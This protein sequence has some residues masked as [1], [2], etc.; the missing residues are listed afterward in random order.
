MDTQ[1]R[2]GMMDALRKGGW[3]DALSRGDCMDT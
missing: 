1:S 2:V 3:T